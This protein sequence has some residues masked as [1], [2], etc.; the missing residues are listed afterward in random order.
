MYGHVPGVALQ[1]SLV[2]MQIADCAGRDVFGVVLG[3]V[4]F[5]GVYAKHPRFLVTNNNS[6]RSNIRD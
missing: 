5:R 6:T 1:L 3:W 2:M 4:A